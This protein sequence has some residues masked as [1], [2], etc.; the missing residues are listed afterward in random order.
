[1][2]RSSIIAFILILGLWSGCNVEKA[3]NETS[4]RREIIA[5]MNAQVEGWNAFDIDKYMGGYLKSDS[6]RFASGGNIQR[7]WHQTLERYK[8]TYPDP[9]AMGKLTFSDLDITVISDDAAIVFG[10]YA[11]EREADQPTG[12]FTLLFR[13]TD[14]GWRIVHDH[15][16]TA[17]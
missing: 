17:N 6:L 2:K 8:R 11:L 13:M 5:V 10:R 14:K 7:G 3:T 12:L 9:Q 4:I 15:T 16:S 1:M